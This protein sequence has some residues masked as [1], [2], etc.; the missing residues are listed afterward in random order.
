MWDDRC[1]N[2][3]LL[4]VFLW[5]KWVNLIKWVNKSTNKTNS[6]AMVST[7]LRV[8]SLDKVGK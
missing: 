1:Q 8:F 3:T 6:L 2:N 5:I 7:L 4:R